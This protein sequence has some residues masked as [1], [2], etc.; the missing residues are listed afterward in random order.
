MSTRRPIRPYAHLFQLGRD[1][2]VGTTRVPPALTTVPCYVYRDADAARARHLDAIAEP[3]MDQATGELLLAAIEGVVDRR[4]ILHELCTDAELAVERA[5]AHTNGF[6]AGVSIDQAREA[7]ERG[8][9]VVHV[10]DDGG[11]EEADDDGARA[12]DDL[13]RHLD[14][15]SLDVTLRSIAARDEE[16]P[17]HAAAIEEILQE[18][19]EGPAPEAFGARAAAR[20]ADAH[21]ELRDVLVLLAARVAKGSHGEQAAPARA[22]F[23]ALPPAADARVVKAVAKAGLG[24][25]D[26][27]PRPARP[28]PV[29]R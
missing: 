18:E 11:E 6:H 12:L 20:L 28:R 16:L 4:G 25:A 21:P 24:P 2:R 19:L 17:V 15:A 13:L 29:R 14:L 3:A 23:S 1:A 5:P 8:G 10:V 7:L 26:D 27:R 9:F 22:L